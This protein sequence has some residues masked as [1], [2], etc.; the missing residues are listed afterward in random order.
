MKKQTQ[1]FL[2]LLTL[3]IIMTQ[4][5]TAITDHIK[6]S[7]EGYI[8]IKQ[9]KLY[10]KSIGQGKP[11]VLIHGGPGLSHNH[12]LPQM[13]ALAANHTLIAYDQRGSGKST[14]Y[15]PDKALINIKQ[16]VSDLEA[17]RLY[18][19]QDKLTLLGHS[20]GTFLA[21][22][23]AI[24]Y[25]QHT[26]KLILMSPQPMC[27]QGMS[28]FEKN[29]QAK[30]KPLQDQLSSLETQK[31]SANDKISKIY[32]ILSSAFCYD[33]RKANALTL[34]YDSVADQ[35]GKTVASHMEKELFSNKWDY[36]NIL[37]KIKVAT[38]VIHGKQDPIPLWV[39]DK[40]CRHIPHAKQLTI[41]KC[42][43]FPYIEQPKI[44]FESIHQF[45]N[46]T[47]N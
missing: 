6:K 28:A 14:P 10:Y 47:K 5:A 46:K 39:A 36:H 12:F 44:F 2:H 25:P 7:T 8:P 19:K 41:D 22:H 13:E 27:H 4:H 20:W 9:G 21:I 40:I 26:E 32:R 11:I 3:G 29:F 34:T 18:L 38:L 23:Y 24:T 30:L 16:F 17:L 37:S 1:F 15:N 35:S 45:L 42:G 33:I 31:L 43:H